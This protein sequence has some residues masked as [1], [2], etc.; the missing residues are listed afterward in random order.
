M[1]FASHFHNSS[2][3]I[4]AATSIKTWWRCSL[5][6]D[7]KGEREHLSG[8]ENAVLWNLQNLSLIIGNLVFVFLFAF[9]LLVLWLSC[10]RSSS[11]PVWDQSGL[12]RRKRNCMHAA[13]WQEGRSNYAENRWCIATLIFISSLKRR[14]LLVLR[15]PGKTCCKLVNRVGWGGGC[16]TV[17]PLLILFWAQPFPIISLALLCQPH[18]EDDCLHRWCT[19]WGLGT[20][21][22]SARAMG[23]CS[24]TQRHTGVDEVGPDEIELLELSG[25]NLG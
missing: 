13:C 11:F 17:N 12:K 3:S 9:L 7:L 19:V 20:H 21:P 15:F 1:Y 2:L 23:C 6:S 16:S 22:D 8:E 24:V 10:R 4:C 18:Q 25:D 14:N 5:Y